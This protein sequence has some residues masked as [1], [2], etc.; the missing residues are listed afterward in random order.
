MTIRRLLFILCLIFSTIAANAQSITEGLQLHYTFEKLSDNKVPDISGNGY[1]GTLMNSATITS[2]KDIG[3]LSLGNLNGYL[4]LGTQIGELIAELE[5]F[6]I[7]TYLYI[8]ENSNITGNGNFVWAFSTHSACSQTAGKYIAYRVNSQRYALSTGGWGNE[9]V[10]IQI[11]SAS[12]KGIW[13]H[14]VYTQSGTTGS[15]YI[16]GKL[17]IKGTAS[18]KPKD[19]KTATTYNWLGRPHFS[20]DT[21]L[22][23]ASYADFR[24]YNKSLTESEIELLLSKLNILNNEINVNDV[25]TAKQS[26]QLDGL[27]AIRKNLM[28]PATTGNNVNISWN[29]SNP[30]VLSNAGIVTRPAVGQDPID[31]LLTATFSKGDYSVLKEFSGRVFPMLSESETVRYDLEKIVLDTEHC[32]YMGQISLPNM[33]EEGSIVTWKSDAKEYITDQGEVVKLPSKGSGTKS[34]T[35]TATTKNGKEEASKDF[36]ICI[37]EDEGYA[38]Y[39]FAYFTGNAVSQEQIFFGLSSDGYVYKALNSKNPI[40]S[41]SDISDKGG[42]RDPH[43]LRGHDGNFYMVVTDMR[44]SEPNC[45]WACNHGIVL[46]KSPDL[47][48]WT[49]SKVDIK[50]Q[51]PDE[52]G[53]INRAWAPQTFYDDKTGKYMVY[54]SMKTTEPDSYDIIYYAYANADFTALESAPKQLF[55]HPDK[56][57]CIDGDIIYRDG[58]YH[59]FFKTED[60]A[61]KGYKKAVSDNLTSGYVL[62]DRY[63]DQTNDA[64]EGACVF[65]MINQEKYILMYDVYTS[66]RYEFTESTD[67][68]NF[69]LTTRTVSMDFSPRHGTVIPITQEEAERVVEKWGNSSM[70][71]FGTAA[72]PQVKPINIE[73]NES[74][75]KVYIPVKYG[76]DISAFDPEIRATVP[77]IPIHPKGMQDFT[78]GPIE[79]TFT[80]G[81]TTK[82]YQVTVSVDN[83]PVI[84]GYYADP[85]I[86]YSEKTGKFYIYPTSDGFSGW[87][88]YF[89]KVFSSDDLVNWTDEGVIIDL[90]ANSTPWA[91]GN[92]WAPCITEKKIN[93][94]Y[95]YFYYFSGGQNGGTK[96]IGVAVADHPTGPFVV[97]PRP[98]IDS[99]PVGVNGGQQIDPDVFTDPKT[100]KSYI[101]W[102]NGYLAAA[103]LNEDMLSLKEN[104]T[105][106]RTPNST[107]REAVYVFCRNDKYYVL[108][109]E[110]DT[111]SRNYKVRYATADSPLGALSIPSDNIVIQR[112]NVKA[113]YGTGHNSIVQIPGKDEWYIVYHRI[114]RP[115]GVNMSSPGNYRE[116]CIDKLEFNADGSI[117]Q[118]IPTLEGI[119][120]IILNQTSIE[121]PAILRKKIEIY[122]T[123]VLDKITIKSE[124]SNIAT[125]TV[126]ILDICGRILRKERIPQGVN[127]FDC[128]FLQKGYYLVHVEVGEAIS[129][130]KIY[131]N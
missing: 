5:D 39:L 98:I 105:V 110:D 94:E 54:F 55:Y 26:F 59:L 96:K 1:D 24:I 25:E 73:V 74:T 40:I 53:N 69:T 83:N 11:G 123:L 42:V 76:T 15:I 23:G 27:D 125:I 107:F 33:G 100:G 113:I 77:G 3:V 4:D 116:V 66:G 29:S 34:V 62:L 31:V 12:A 37:Q 91:N 99:F 9:K 122:P 112:D 92:T 80:Y 63:L 115:K 22:K 2:A 6:S 35:L 14:L 106:V 131:K 32:Y 20:G 102:G 70:V 128:S 82:S 46:L 124:D 79:Y 38:G 78:Q 47:I 7:A 89:M 86:L 117:K 8:E 88:G 68:E 84:T 50:A 52:F 51:F 57:S 44:T 60:A 43:I 81:A 130:S 90:H 49:H 126:S 114:S 16:D 104:T 87:G 10:G 111:G 56:V 17:I 28:L 36:L 64:V 101:Y 19:N 108:W 65:R 21:Y 61:D 97:Q 119:E 127:E 109:S 71:I 103:E 72:S 121:K 93:G 95:K 67:L 58:K 18:L 75:K 48:N 129:V 30:A 41:A 120:P 45:N 118:T 85:E 13:Q